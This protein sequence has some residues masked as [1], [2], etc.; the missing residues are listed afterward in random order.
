MIRALC[1]ACLLVAS[2]ARAGEPI[3]PVFGF[4]RSST[5]TFALT[6]SSIRAFDRTLKQTRQVTI[7]VAAYAIAL[8]PDQKE[9]AVARADG[10]WL[11][12]PATLKEKKLVHVAGKV[13]K[14]PGATIESEDPFGEVRG[15]AYTSDG[16][17]IS[18]SENGALC[19]HAK[20]VCYDAMASHTGVIPRG[21]PATFT[22]SGTGAVFAWRAS[23][24]ITLAAGDKPVALGDELGLPDNLTD[25]L[26][27]AP[28]GW[29]AIAYESNSFTLLAHGHKK[30]EYY[31]P[32]VVMVAFSPNGQYL[33][34]STKDAVARWDMRCVEKAGFKSTRLAKVTTPVFALSVGDAGD[35][36]GGDITGKVITIAP[37]DPNAAKPGC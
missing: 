33:V 18:M 13:E 2:V 6:K 3:D 10:I 26:A 7:P 37:D 19:F 1:I 30:L 31:T 5:T 27:A 4:A 22:A 8:S 28:T 32:G 14:L 20:G 9:L 36:I 17:L 25:A 12:D 21:M 24:L 34:T 23:K 15:V 29:V 11:L 35:V 16:A